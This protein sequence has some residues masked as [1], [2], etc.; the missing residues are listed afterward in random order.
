MTIGVGTIL[1]AKRVVLI[2]AGDGKAEILRRTIEEPPS[3]EVPASW[4]RL[5]GPRLEIIADE[6]AA[7]ALTDFASDAADTSTTGRN[8][9]ERQR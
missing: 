1:A 3:Q 6:A 2:V 8:A 5:A 4:L 9:H 7:S